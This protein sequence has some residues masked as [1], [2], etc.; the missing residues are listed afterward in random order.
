MSAAFDVVDTKILL[1]KCWIFNFNQ[2]T[3]QWF[4]SYLTMRSQCTYIS[5]STSSYLTLVDGVPQGSMLGPAL[6]TLYTYDFPEVVHEDDCPNSPLSRP[7][8]KMAMYRTI[9]M[10]MVQ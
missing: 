8:G 5:G 9:C 10:G 3:E 4:W 6:Y 2:E 1:E 7:P